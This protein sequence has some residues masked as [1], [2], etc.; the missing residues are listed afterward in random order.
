MKLASFDIFDTVLVRKCGKPD[1]IFYLLAHHLYPGDAAKREEFFLWRKGAEGAAA[2]TLNGRQTTI[3]DIYS[4][5]GGEKFKE[6]TLQQLIDAEKAV[7]SENLTANPVIKAVIEKH[8]NESFDICF[9]SDMYLPGE[10][11]AS[12]LRREGCLLGNER[13]FVSCEEGAR[14]STGALYDKVRGIYNPTHWEHYGDH[15]VSDVK[16]AKEKG[17]KAHLV[18][19]GYTE[20]ETKLT[21]TND[22][23]LRCLAGLQRAAR[24]KTG[25]S[26]HAALAADFV[27]PAYI[28]YVHF[29]MQK[30]TERGIKKLY[31]L[32]RDSY[33]LQKI[34]EQAQTLYPAIELKYLFVSRKALLLPYLQNPTAEK[35]LAVQ[36]KRTLQGQSVEKLLCS[37]GTSTK[38]LKEE[39]STAFAF[40][41]VTNKNEEQEFLEKIFGN[42]STFKP[43]L[44]ELAREK[45]ALLNGYF[46]QE[47]L[48]TNEK[49]AMVD[50]GW[51]GTTR[52]M[53]NSI[54]REEGHADTLFFYYGVRGDVY[55]A[56][57]GAFE[58]FYKKG[59][60]TTTLTTLIENYFSSSPYPSTS[61][62]ERENNTIKP[63]FAAGARY[64]ENNI[65]TAN[66]NAAT[67]L[68]REI[69]PAAQCATGTLRDWCKEAAEA[70]QA[71]N[72]KDIDITPL[73]EAEEFD[74]QAFVRKLSPRE[75]LNIM[76][77]G[78][79][80]TA[81][82]KASIRLTV[83]A[84]AFPFVWP[85]CYIT[86]QA[87]RFLYL[88][89]K[90]KRLQK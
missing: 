77:L 43:R 7:E 34:A 27:A 31:F 65:T 20:T 79:R 69:M 8:R 68:A 85:L 24:I 36:D 2:A 21:Q 50:V 44:Q 10:L 18:K 6:H 28:P 15:P 29:V 61:G 45:R 67:F 1:N 71:L 75:L 57:H 37:L 84:K 16:R 53:I 73:C 74:G 22:Y 88:T 70:A 59:E 11:L 78:G 23:A 81:F 64:K 83:G 49:T 54:L 12:V 90:G 19:S 82:D 87:R 9:I 80:C 51:L 41:K 55:G 56:E 63:T 30:A 3:D 46:A 89:L 47:G 66:T 58:S 4:R 60:L 13:V 33:I 48:Y 32:S 52:L 42:G 35:F 38:E 72:A 17:I 86:G 26:A 5:G 25:N 39:F 62:Y 14:K 76:F 40:T